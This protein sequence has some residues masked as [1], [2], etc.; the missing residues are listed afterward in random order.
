MF[1]RHEIAI[2]IAALTL[3]A[4]STSGQELS[5]QELSAD[6]RRVL[7]GHTETAYDVAFSPDSRLL[8]TASF[9]KTIKLWD[10]ESGQLIDCLLYTSPSPR[11]PD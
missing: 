10:V 4:L 3:S 11:D 2:V 1:N 5:A 8:A 7:E 6:S 9:D